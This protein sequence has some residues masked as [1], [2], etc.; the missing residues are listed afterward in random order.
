MMTKKFLKRLF[1]S[2]SLIGI[3]DIN[4]I[5]I[6][7]GDRPSQGLCHCNLSLSL[8]Y[9]IIVYHEYKMIKILKYT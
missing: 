4:A 5:P 3:L 9:Y 1:Y 2:E 7:S 6:P 8:I